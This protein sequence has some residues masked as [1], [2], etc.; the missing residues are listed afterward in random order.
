[1]KKKIGISILLL[2]VTAIQAQKNNVSK[3]KTISKH[4]KLVIGIVVDQMRYDYLYR[5]ADKYGKGGFNR[6]LSQGF[7]CSNTNYNYVPTYTGPG[8]AAIYTGTTPQYNGII[9]NDWYDAKIGRSVYVTEDTTVTTIGSESTAGKMSPRKLLSTTITDELQLSNNKQSKVIGICLKDRGSI[10]P[11]G[12]FPAAAYWFDNKSGNWITSSY[13]ANQL[14]L[15]VQQFNT[16]KL[17]D[18]YLAKPWTTLFPIEQYTVGLANG[19]SFR[20]PYKG[21]EKNEFPH[22]LPA[23]KNAIGYELIRST[24][25]GNS[26][27]VDFAIEALT[28]EKMGTGKFTD[29]LALSFSSTDY[30]G[31]QFGINAIETQ[32]TYARLDKDLERLFAHLDKT[33]GMDNVLIFLTADHGAAETPAH[34]QSLN[35]PSGVFS[36]DKIKEKL[37]KHISAIYGEGNWILHYNNQQFWLNN[38]L[39]EEKKLNKKELVDNCILFLKKMEGVQ[40][41]YN[42]SELSQLNTANQHIDKLVLGISPIRSGD[43]A[44]VLQP[45]WFDAPYAAKGGTTHGSGFAYDTHVPLLWLGWKIKQGSSATPVNITD[46]AATLSNLL[47]ISKTNASIGI[48]INKLI[49][50][51]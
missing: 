4:P 34:M 49:N 17:C 39:I 24:P 29:F 47:H 25:F 50:K 45:G 8:H 51:K 36:S 43:I 20:N 6:F 28:Q 31:H 22:D 44:I 27:T 19:S 5:F 23:I 48:P 3:N 40:D 33:I 2:A 38:V 1:M 16:K 35:I 46:I 10:L 42:T 37:S 26:F 11:A 41:V 32:D 9:A 18:Q 7:E 30:V 13:Y 14:P 12:H 15:W 21:E